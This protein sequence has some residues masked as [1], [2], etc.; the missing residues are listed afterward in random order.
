MPVFLTGKKILERLPHGA[1]LGEELTVLA[2]REGIKAGTV[3]AIGAVRKATIG[4]YDQKEKEY[5]EREVN[6]PM[7]ICSC[8][9]NISLKN[10]EIF[11]HAHITLA[12]REGRVVGGHLCEGTIIFAAECLIEELT[13]EELHRLYDD[14][15][16][17][18]LWK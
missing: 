8:L 14:T 17:L 2:R 13:G 7:E 10:G 16:G 1:D 9:G 12:D 11:V 18:S 6:G 15:T 4:Y 3:A 5:R